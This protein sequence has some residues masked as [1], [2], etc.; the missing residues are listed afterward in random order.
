M[1]FWTALRTLTILPSPRPKGMEDFGASLPYFPLVGTVVA[2]ISLGLVEAI[3]LLW[4]GPYHELGPFLILASTTVLTRGLHLD[5]L[6]D[7][8][9]SL[10]AYS[11]E[12]RL[13]IMKDKHVG[14]FGVVAVCL[15]LGG[16]YLGLKALIASDRAW[17]F[18]LIA[19]ISRALMAGLIGALPYARKESGMGEPFVKGAG[20][21]S[22]FFP[23][24]YCLT[25]S[26]IFYP[27][28]FLLVLTA[29]LLFAILRGYFMRRYGGITGDLLGASN[30][31]TELSLLLVSS[32]IIKPGG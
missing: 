19:A 2:A 16:K 5:G 30:E 4:P 12:T 23:L 22:I 24:L 8:A 17:S 6:A 3:K 32:F 31:I 11:A 9:D 27:M 14:A 26:L 10:G 13:A 15:I 1:S 29:L 20:P 18:V 7:W 21:R 28:G 25:L